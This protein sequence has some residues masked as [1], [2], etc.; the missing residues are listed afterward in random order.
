[1]RRQTT[2]WTNQ[3]CLAQF[4]RNCAVYFVLFWVKIIEFQSVFYMDNMM[5]MHNNFS[6]TLTERTLV[7]VAVVLSVWI[8]RLIYIPCPCFKPWNWHRISARRCTTCVWNDNIWRNKWM[9][10]K[11]NFKFAIVMTPKNGTRKSSQRKTWREC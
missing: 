5:T 1:M 6:Y 10:K 11:H 8:C 4:E 2:I 9:K 7:S 3:S